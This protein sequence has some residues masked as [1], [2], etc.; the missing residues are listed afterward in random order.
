[1]QLKTSEI[2]MKKLW[3]VTGAATG[4]GLLTAALITLGVPAAGA[5]AQGCTFAQGGAAAQQCTTVIG[6]GLHVNEIDN[7]YYASPVSGGTADVCNRHH[8]ITY[9][10][11]NGTKGTWSANPS[12]CILGSVAILT[13]D[14]QYVYPNRNFPNNK[15]ICSRSRNSDTNEVWTPYACVTIHS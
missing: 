9:Y 10:N 14:E 1:M 5:S 13:G 8:Q 2:A 6:S 12:S 7:D 11:A 15:S 3:R 4:C